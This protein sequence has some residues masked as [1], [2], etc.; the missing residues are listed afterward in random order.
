M[1]RLLRQQTNLIEHMRILEIT[2]EN[3]SIY[4]KLK[5]IKDKKGREQHGLFFIEGRRFVAEAIQRNVGIDI[6]CM[7]K[8]YYDRFGQELVELYGNQLSNTTWVLLSDKLMD[9]LTDT[10]SDQGLCAA[11]EIPANKP[12]PTEG[13]QFY[14]LLDKLQDPGNLGT[15]IRTCHAAG[16]TGIVL[17]NQCVDPYNT[18]TLRST[19]GSIFALNIH[20]VK[21]LAQKIG[22]MRQDGYDIYAA[23]LENGRPYTQLKLWEPEKVAIVIGNEGNGVSQEVIDA[24]TG[25]VYI[26]M[27]G[28]SES[29]NA[30][31]AAS[32]LIYERIRQEI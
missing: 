17:G 1:L 7:G 13:R 20:R 29:L 6:L 26:P 11:V 32:I 14:V 25:N 10:V 2:S 18:K 21:D 30:S 4:K 5:S 22:E 24:C 19:M 3:N 31:A 15:I 9:G 8:K 23:A 16:A 27:P 28:G 12:V